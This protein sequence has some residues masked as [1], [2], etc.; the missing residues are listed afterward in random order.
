M[1]LFAQMAPLLKK[2][3]S[4]LKKEGQYCQT[5]LFL[6]KMWCRIITSLASQRKWIEIA[7]SNG[8]DA[9]Y[10]DLDL[11]MWMIDPKSIFVEMPLYILSRRDCNID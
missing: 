3:T 5:K 10:L 7:N 4:P 1:A 8:L 9:L 11:K 2:D 6:D